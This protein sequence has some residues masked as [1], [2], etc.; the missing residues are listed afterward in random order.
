MIDGTR[1]SQTFTRLYGSGQGVFERQIKRWGCLLGEFHRRFGEREIRFFCAP[2]RTEI[3]GNHTDHN[4]G[5]VLAAGIDLDSIAIASPSA[6][7]K[8][9][10]HSEGYNLPF[11]VDL[12]D[13][14][15][16]AAEK[17]T[18]AALIRGIASRFRQL[19]Y[20]IGGFSA[21]FAS[22]VPVGSGLSSSASIEVLIAT[23]LNALFNAGKIEAK[24]IAIIGQHAENVYFGK[25]CGLMDQIACAVGGI[26]KIDFENPASPL[27][28]KVEFDIA[29]SGYSLLVVDTGG[30]HA[31][32]T[33][34][35]AAIPREM[36]LVAAQLGK[37]VCRQIAEREV[38]NAIPILRK[39]AGDRA[40]LRAL[41]YL[42]ENERVDLEVAAL[43]SRDMRRF[44]QIIQE[45]GDSSYRWLQNCVSGH[46]GTE[47]G[48]PL[49]LAIAERFTRRSG[50]ACRVHGGG[51]AGTIQVF[52]PDGELESF[53]SAMES[54]F[55][56]GSVKVLR[57]RSQGSH[58]VV[59]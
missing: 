13:L 8:I 24:E 9:T 16:V 3:G 25:P 49:A 31:D 52:L 47:Q 45:S 18:T 11:V 41:H 6:D 46:A 2:G 5:K 20:A 44:L 10:I 42:Q 14:S 21:C 39:R 35:Y 36:K 58:E 57:V 43:R 22:E 50:G 59:V 51:F 37:E 12:E 32:L 33:E 19:G 48:I 23:I 4:L 54:V 38:L 30:S 56:P 29:A 53:R 40:I 34:D 55:G 26:V 28:E 27:I 15:V 1:W 17:G 7:N